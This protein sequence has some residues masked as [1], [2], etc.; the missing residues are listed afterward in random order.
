M[1]GDTG[2]QHTCGLVEFSRVD[3]GLFL[4]ARC[5][6]TLDA[7]MSPPTLHSHPPTVVSP[8]ALLDYLSLSSSLSQPVVIQVDGEPSGVYFSYP[9]TQ[10]DEAL[11]SHEKPH[12]K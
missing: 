3:S 9:G 11:L 8:S 7:M 5:I 1:G 10:L 12:L 6:Y 4:S 2:K